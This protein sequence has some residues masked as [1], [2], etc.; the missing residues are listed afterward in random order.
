MVDKDEVSSFG[1]AAV[2]LAIDS[3]TEN[4]KKKLV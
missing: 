3:R 1:R 2:L 4:P